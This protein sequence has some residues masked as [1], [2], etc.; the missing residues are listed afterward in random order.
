MRL[1]WITLGTILLSAQASANIE[2]QLTQC[3]DIND[4]LERLAC[5]DTLANN[6]TSAMPAIAAAP[7]IVPVVNAKPALAPAEPVVVAAPAAVAA[8]SNTATSAATPVAPQTN[9][10][11]FGLTK[12]ADE[13]VIEKVYMDIASVKKDPYGALIITFTN[14]QVWKQT[15]SKSFKLKSGETVYIEKGALSSFILSSDSR[16]SSI[17]VKRL[18]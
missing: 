4:K 14:G 11:E 9:V 18:Q 2:Q 1:T 15:E 12:K 7:A 6:V 8:V 10:D 16:N 3:A 5:Y 13:V 17:R